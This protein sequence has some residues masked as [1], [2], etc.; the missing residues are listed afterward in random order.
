MHASNFFVVMDSQGL[1]YEGGN[2]RKKVEA[3]AAKW[4]LAEL[5]N[6]IDV[7]GKVQFVNVSTHTSY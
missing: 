3:K 7:L 4:S 1:V 2:T 6:G 5:K